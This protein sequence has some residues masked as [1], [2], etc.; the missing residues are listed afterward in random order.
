MNLSK[1]KKLPFAIKMIMIPILVGLSTFFV[2]SSLSVI[3]TIMYPTDYT[4]VVVH[5]VMILFTMVMAVISFFIWGI[6]L[7]ERDDEQR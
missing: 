6:E 3:I 7:D 5:P 2:T 4:S 1:L